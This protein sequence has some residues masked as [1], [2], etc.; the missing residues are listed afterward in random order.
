MAETYDVKAGLKNVLDRIEL[1]S[2]NR[3]E[4]VK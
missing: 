3:P 1:A 4:K 2:K